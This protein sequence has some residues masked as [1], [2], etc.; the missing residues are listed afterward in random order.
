M[1]RVMRL[2]AFPPG[3][4][5][6]AGREIAALL[7]PFDAKPRVPIAR[8]PIVTA[9]VYSYRRGHRQASSFGVLEAHALMN[10][11]VRLPLYPFFVRKSS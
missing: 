10:G 7:D 2:P 4:I 3:E 5:R 8:P 9:R 1:R 11:E 6:H